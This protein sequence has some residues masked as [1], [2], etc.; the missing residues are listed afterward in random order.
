LHHHFTILPHD[1]ALRS[2]ATLA[3][4][5]I[6]CQRPES[7]RMKF[8]LTGQA[9]VVPRLVVRRAASG[10]PARLRQADERFAQG[11]PCEGQPVPRRAI[12][13]RRISVSDMKPRPRPS[14]APP[15]TDRSPCCH[16]C[17]EHNSRCPSGAVARRRSA[18]FRT[19]PIYDLCADARFIPS[20]T[21]GPS[22]RHAGLR[23]RCRA[24]ARTDLPQ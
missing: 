24:N 8:V 1:F 11:A 12:W 2:Q 9:P 14:S 4:K 21:I 16:N 22:V 3:E 17:S 23:C 19:P 5:S 6:A 20:T 13:P 10:S 18:P 7:S 15:P